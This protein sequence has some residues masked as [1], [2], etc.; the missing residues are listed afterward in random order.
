[1]LYFI[2]PAFIQMSMDKSSQI[3]GKMQQFVVVGHICKF[4][5]SSDGHKKFTAL[6]IIILT[7]VS[8][9]HFLFYTVK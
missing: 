6:V 8:T 2:V 3:R 7:F 5:E 9:N 1:M 4:C